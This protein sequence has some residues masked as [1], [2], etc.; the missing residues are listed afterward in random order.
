MGQRW[1]TI[2]KTEARQDQEVASEM[3]AEMKWCSAT[4]LIENESAAYCRGTER[5]RE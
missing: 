1:E 3:Q 2:R 5:R 4:G